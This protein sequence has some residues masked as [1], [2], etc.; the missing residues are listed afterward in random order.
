MVG[1]ARTDL[2]EDRMLLF[3]VVRGMEVMGEAASRLPEDVRERGSGNPVG[4]DRLAAQR[5]KV[6]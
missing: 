2:D 4:C 3:A 5:V 6:K 1:R